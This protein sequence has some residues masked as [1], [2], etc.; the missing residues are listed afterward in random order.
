MLPARPK[1]TGSRRSY[2]E[3]ND[4]DGTERLLT[5][6]MPI[7]TRSTRDIGGKDVDVIPVPSQVFG[8]FFADR[9]ELRDELR[10]AT[11]DALR[12]IAA[13]PNR[14]LR[15]RDFVVWVGTFTN[16]IGLDLAV[17]G[18]PDGVALAVA[19]SFYATVPPYT[20]LG[21]YPW[22]DCSAVPYFRYDH[23]V[24][25]EY[26]SPAAPGVD[27]QGDIVARGFELAD[28][29]QKRPTTAPITSFPSLRASKLHSIDTWLVT[30]EQIVKWI[31][32]LEGAVSFTGLRKICTNYFGLSVFLE[33][34]PEIVRLGSIRTGL[35]S[36]SGECEVRILIASSLPAEL[37]RVVLAH[38][39]AHYALHFP[40]VYGA[41]LVE[42]I[43]WD[44][45][46]LQLVYRSILASRFRRGLHDLEEDADRFAAHCLIP[47]MYLPLGRMASVTLEMGRQ[48][49]G[50]ELAWRFLQ[51]LFPESGLTTYSWR[52]WDEM[53]SR[54]QRE[55]A[56][57]KDLSIAEADDLYLRMLLATLENEAGGR[58]R[59]RM[60]EGV[61]ECWSELTRVLESLEVAS[62][63]A[64]VRA[65]L[66]GYGDWED[67]SE[68]ELFPEFGH[69][70]ELL[71][72]LDETEGMFPVVPLAPA[73]R[74][75]TGAKQG[76]WQQLNE[77][78]SPRPLV[79]WRA[80]TADHGV[81]LY[82]PETWQT[83]RH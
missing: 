54:A 34:R 31:S 26:A 50:A 2:S 38:E 22:R 15:E 48:P 3:N 10:S 18:L 80:A 62:T 13:S 19:E 24:V 37:K 12:H 70:R 56:F 5:R 39:L 79:E 61:Q 35:I 20:D 46:E 81:M 64:E 68:G 30:N 59:K 52:N 60:V 29:S 36:P 83:R 49:T 67:G 47:P 63:P 75:K 53:L 77:P 8:I 43:S 17:L 45:P 7:H 33:P 51:P 66:T 25:I 41:Q 74:N 82:F 76:L 58:N 21:S 1:Q 78:S 40:L 9:G 11:M 57:V 42:E 44:I 23:G 4:S 27:H 73:D 71:P 55:M 65:A 69:R 28:G 72:P 16:R 14:R 32:A 6:P